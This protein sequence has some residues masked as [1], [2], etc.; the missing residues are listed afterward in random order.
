MHNIYFLIIVGHS[1]QIIDII[2]KINFISKNICVNFLK[3]HPKRKTNVRDR[4]E[5]ESYYFI[6]PLVHER[7]YFSI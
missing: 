1:L 6:K 5:H 2:T 7:F 3:K 4:M